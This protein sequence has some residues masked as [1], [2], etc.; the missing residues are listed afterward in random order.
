MGWGT[1]SLNKISL[2]L[3]RMFK[4]RKKWVTETKF[5]IK[6][7]KSRKRKMRA[8]KEKDIKGVQKKGRRE[9]RRKQTRGGHTKWLWE[10]ENPKPGSEAEEGRGGPLGCLALYLGSAQLS[11]EGRLA[12][13]GK[14]L[15]GIL[16]DHLHAGEALGKAWVLGHLRLSLWMHHNSYAIRNVTP[17]TFSFKCILIVHL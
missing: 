6:F 13:W 12:G 16:E 4:F 15:L 8:R 17:H 10:K 11:V 5:W 1:P 3:F 9:T 2:G 14:E 7:F